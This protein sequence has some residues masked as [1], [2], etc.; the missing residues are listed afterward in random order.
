[1]EDVSRVFLDLERAAGERRAPEATAGALLLATHAR[2]IPEVEPIGAADDRAGFGAARSRL[3]T[4]AEELAAGSKDQDERA[5]EIALH[6][7]RLGCV[8]C[9]VQFRDAGGDAFPAR[10]NTVWGRVRLE[11][12]DGVPREEREDVVLFLDLVA[13]GAPAPPAPVHP[14]MSQKGQRFLPRVL[15]VV[16]GTEVRFPN[17]DIVFHNVFSLSK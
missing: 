10:R 12:M 5:V 1:M 4:L 6:R 13:D 9:H 14:S 11:T 2:A 7:L 8:S 15:P 16:Q 3:V 17:D